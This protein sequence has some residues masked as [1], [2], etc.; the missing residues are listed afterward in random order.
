[1]DII[2]WIISKL[3][4]VGFILFVLV[5]LLGVWKENRYRAASF[6]ALFSFFERQFQNDTIEMPSVAQSKVKFGF[7]NLLKLIYGKNKS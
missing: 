5:V 2:T 4:L 7:I 6:G 1:M 3:L